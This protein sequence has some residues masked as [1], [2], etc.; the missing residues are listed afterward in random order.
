MSPSPVAS[1]TTL[2]RM[3]W[4]PSLL[5][6]MTPLTVLPSMMGLV[7]QQWIITLML[8]SSSTMASISSFSWVG[9]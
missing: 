2:A 3:A 8:G 6:K 4:R 9:S 5:S 7:P 1:M